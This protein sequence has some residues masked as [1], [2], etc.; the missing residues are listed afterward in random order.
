MQTACRF[1]RLIVVLALAMMAMSAVAQDG[2]DSVPALVTTP[3]QFVP[4]PPCRVVDT[5][6]ADGN[7]G[8]PPIQGG[9][10]GRNFPIGQGNCAVPLGATAFSLNITVVPMGSLRFLTVWPTGLQQPVTST[11]NSGDGRIKANAA[12]VAAGNMGGGVSVYASDTTNVIIDVNGYF[13]PAKVGSLTFYP[14]SPC[15]VWDTRPQYGGNGPLTGGIA[16]DFTIAGSTCNVPATAKVYSLNVTAVPVAT[17]SYLTVFPANESGTPPPVST[18]NDTTGT[19]VANAA[20]VGAGVGGDIAVFPTNDTNVIIDIDGY[21]APPG[22]Q[23]AL[24]LY[25][26]TPCRVLDTRLGSGAFSGMI[27]VPVVSSPCGL[28][29]SAQGYVLNATVLPQGGGLGYLT[30]WPDGVPQPAVST[31][32]ALDGYITN[33]MAIVTTTNG[34]IDAYASSLTQLLL[35]VSAYFAP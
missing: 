30:L 32:N 15:R 27:V 14:L 19:I 34:S 2:T 7:F 18:L 23:N 11:L 12:I 1:V 31:L 24:S 6:L 26:T 25:V 22:G 17:L 3:Y 8:G 29:A 21:F 16:K 20:I 35:D 4:L 10:P 9:A 28:P 13:A 33:N 5:R